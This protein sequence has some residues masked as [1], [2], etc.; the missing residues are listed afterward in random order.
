[1]KTF[2][3]LLRVLFTDP[4]FEI[5]MIEVNKKMFPAKLHSKLAIGFL[6]VIVISTIMTLLLF[7]FSNIIR[8]VFYASK[9]YFFI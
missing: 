3:L 6:T 8:I 5:E 7:Y 1:M 4:V 2:T 9:K